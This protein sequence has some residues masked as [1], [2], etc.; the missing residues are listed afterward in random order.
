MTP[1]EGH[2]RLDEG[3]DL[4]RAEGQGRRDG[5]RAHLAAERPRAICSVCPQSLRCY[6]WVGECHSAHLRVHASF[7][8]GSCQARLD[9]ECIR[10]NA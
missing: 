6:E 5:S 10:E 1:Q 7:G 3:R 8:L 2:I 9:F 4:H